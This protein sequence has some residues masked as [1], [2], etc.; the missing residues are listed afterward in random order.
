MAR[1]RSSAQGAALVAQVEI[2]AGAI[3]LLPVQ[4]DVAKRIGRLGVVEHLLDQGQVAP[5]PLEFGRPSSR[6][7]LAGPAE[8][9]KRSPRPGVTLVGGHLEP[10]G[11][12][13]L[14]HRH[15]FAFKI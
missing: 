5:C 12:H 14:V 1:R 15:A 9:V 11:G 7:L 4:T 10:L 2:Q 6:R 3:H 8:R 13:A